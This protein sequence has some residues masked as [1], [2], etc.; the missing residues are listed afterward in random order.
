MPP[1][2][3]FDAVIIVGALSEGQV[4]CCA[5]PELLRVTKPG[6]SQSSQPL[7]SCTLAPLHS[8]QTLAQEE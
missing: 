7:P 3:T 6:E 1:T 2:G 5:I 8:T 4:P